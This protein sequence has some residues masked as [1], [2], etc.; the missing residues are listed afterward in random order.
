MSR[1]FLDLLPLPT[2]SS[3]DPLKEL[4][5]V[6]GYTQKLKEELVIISTVCPPYSAS[7]NGT[8]TYEGLECG[9]SFNIEQHFKYIPPVVDLLRQNGL[10]VKHLFLMADTEVDLLP[11]LVKLD[12]TPEEFTRRCQLSVEVIRE[13]VMQTYPELIY[14]DINPPAARFLSFFGHQSWYQRYEYYTDRLLNEM[15]SD[16]Y[17]R[18]SR[19][20]SFDMAEREALIIKLLGRVSKEEKLRHIARQKAQYMAFASLMRVRFGR[21]LVVV[22]HRTPNF[23]WMNDRITREPDDPIQ[24]ANGNYLPKLPLIELDITTLPEV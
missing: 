5:Q 2:K 7:E 4:T 15:E 3:S 12:L 20:L 10:S 14:D 17:G 11:F 22:N 16:P 9:I 23:D 24:L 19:G 6:I 1:D 13:K 21:R 8:P 18:I